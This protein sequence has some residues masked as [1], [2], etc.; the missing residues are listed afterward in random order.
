[1]VVV[2]VSALVSCGGGGGGALVRNTGLTAADGMA[3]TGCARS[4]WS[5]RQSGGTGATE[6]PS[7]N[8]GAAEAPP[9][10]RSKLQLPSTSIYIGPRSE[11]TS[12]LQASLNG[13]AA[14]GRCASTHCLRATV[15]LQLQWLIYVPAGL[16]K[17]EAKSQPVRDPT[18]G[19]RGQSAPTRPGPE[20]ACQAD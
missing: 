9:P 17:A 5:G 1:M 18:T 4:D 3:A 19:G 14:R 13:V 10:R 12:V 2:V 15:N 11:S 16:L 8:G 20:V 7:P 6:T